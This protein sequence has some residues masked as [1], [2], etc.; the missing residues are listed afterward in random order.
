MR[1]HSSIFILEE[2][3]RSMKGIIVG[4][5]HPDAKRL[6]FQYV[7]AQEITQDE[8][9]RGEFSEAEVVVLR[10]YTLLGKNELDKLKNLKY[11]VNCSVGT[12]NISID[13]LQRRGIRLISCSGT[14]ANS[15][16]E[17]TLYLLMA[18]LRQD[19]KK[20]FFELKNKTVGIVGF[21]NIGK[22]VARKLIGFDV[23]I[24]AYDVIPPDVNVTDEFKVEMTDLFSLA[25]Q[26]NVVTIHVPLNS[27][28][29]GLIRTDFLEKM[30][31]GSFFINTSRAEVIN[32][33][34]L[35]RAWKSG[36]LRGLGLDVYS[37]NL[38][39]KLRNGNIFFTE[40]VAAQG[41]DSFREMCM[42]PLLQFL[43]ETGMNM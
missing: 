25:Q 23:K 31:E 13:E 18:L 2:A 7:D 35:A 17:H 14:N 9:Y 34:A 22:L 26:S 24:L 42:A 36:K 21:G 8:F 32:E 29:Q 43:K 10:T 6:F 1:W 20:P 40:H 41:E 28:T 15:V 30:R 27:H 16:A 4:T 12:D 11:V 38:K 19:T 33:N 37:D 39:K 3:K 5:V